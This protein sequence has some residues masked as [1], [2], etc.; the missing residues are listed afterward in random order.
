M[1]PHTRVQEGEGGGGQETSGPRGFVCVLVLR[2]G[3]H[4]GIGIFFFFSRQP[5]AIC[6]PTLK[7]TCFC[8]AVVV[9][10]QQR[11]DSERCDDQA[12]K[13]N[14]ETRLRVIS[15]G[16]NQDHR[17]HPHRASFF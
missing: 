5:D 7:T 15:D 8:C 11:C 3:V 9:S 4:M 10:C 16:Y 17:L 13:I 6:C 14:K 12:Q 2:A 1:V